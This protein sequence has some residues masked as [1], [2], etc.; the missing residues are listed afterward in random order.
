MKVIRAH[1]YPPVTA[2]P[3]PNLK[4]F[5]RIM[6]AFIVGAA[7]C[8]G[9]AITIAL[10]NPPPRIVAHSTR[11]CICQKVGTCCLHPRHP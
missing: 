6:A 5:R 3:V 1:D 11:R 9:I 10:R 7:L 4:A 8:M 2:P